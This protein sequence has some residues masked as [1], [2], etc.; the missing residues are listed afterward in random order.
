MLT[1]RDAH[2]KSVRRARVLIAWIQPGL[3]RRLQWPS[4]PWSWA[5]ACICHTVATNLDTCAHH[6]SAISLPP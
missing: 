3:W 4:S 6:S 1:F 5:W 2:M